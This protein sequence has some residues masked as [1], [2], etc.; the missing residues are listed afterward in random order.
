MRRPSVV[1]AVLLILGSALLLAALFLPSGWQDT[2]PPKEQIE[3]PALSGVVLLRIAFLFDGLALLYLGAAGLRYRRLLTNER[4]LL[5]PIVDGPLKSR[6]T[7]AVGIVAATVAG[8][9]LRFYHLGSPLW[10]D[11]I[12]PRLDYGEATY[13]QI[14]TSFISTNN[15]LLYTL[16]TKFWTGLF[17]EREW[18]IRLP[19]ALAGVATIPLFYAVARRVL[20]RACSLGAVVMLAVSYHHV[21]FSQNGR[22]YTIYLLL[23]ALAS[24]LLAQGLSE[25]SPRVWFVYAAVMTLNL[26]V[27]M[28]SGFVYIAHVVIG[29]AA[30]GAVWRAGGEPSLLLRRLVAVFGAVG[31]LGF[32]LYAAV[33]PSM[34]AYMRYVYSQQSTGF[35][36][37]SLEFAE[38]MAR[39]IVAG[40]CGS[41]ILPAL[42]FLLLAAAGYWRLL[43]ANWIV[44]LALTLP[45]ITHAAFLVLRG[46]TFSPRFFLLLLLVAILSAMA[47]VEV[48]V[49]I[50]RRLWPKAPV[51]GLQRLSALIAVGL[52]TIVSVRALPHY[53]RVPK[54]DYAAAVAHLEAIRTPADDVIIVHYAESGFLYYGTRRGQ[55]GYVYLRSADRLRAASEGSAG[56]RLVLA[57]T[58]H[59][60]LRLDQ[61]ELWALIEANWQIVKNF[62]STVG[63]G[64]IAIWLPKPRPAAAAMR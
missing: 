23:S 11:E 43:C 30:I 6:R 40:F 42:I 62:P 39:G 19:A 37:V 18:I 41:A 26:S 53:Y 29:V 25:D 32:T 9:A 31:L 4:V 63:D 45:P 12:T 5:V 49:D 2:L 58:F 51:R 46:L 61:P 56:R 21:F 13:L 34:S 50:L 3:P 36:V 1:R 28:I 35:S 16:M 55:A 64:E 33:L 17:G 27:F 48:I 59:R 38:E 24:L 8:A 22:G 47:S 20:S 54:Q 44:T 7:L 52:F 57:T 15:H 14:L 60:A 10:L